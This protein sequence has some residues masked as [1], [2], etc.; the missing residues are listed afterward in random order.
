MQ[1]QVQVVLFLHGRNT[2]PSVCVC[3][4]SY[5]TWVF[6]LQAVFVMKTPEPYK[7]PPQLL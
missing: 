7:L 2:A 4:C 5:E 3:V 1:E 6:F